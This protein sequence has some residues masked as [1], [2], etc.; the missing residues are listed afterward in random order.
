MKDYDQAFIAKRIKELCKSQKIPLKTML[1]D[2]GVGV[3]TISHFE[4]GQKISWLT[5][6]HF[7]DYLDCSLDYLLGRT[8]DPHFLHVVEALPPEPPSSVRYAAFGGGTLQAESTVRE[9]DEMEQAMGELS[10][11]QNGDPPETP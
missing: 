10:R 9:T 5:L 4:K 6:A 1:A 3:N 7:A 2:L 11:L 8:N